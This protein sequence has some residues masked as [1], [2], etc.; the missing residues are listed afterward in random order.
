VSVKFYSPYPKSMTLSRQRA[1]GDWLPWQHYADDCQ[2]AFSLANNGQLS[3]PDDINCLQFDTSV[4]SDIT[5]HI[6]V[7]C[8]TDFIWVLL[9]YLL[10]HILTYDVFDSLRHNL[11]N[12]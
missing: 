8:K 6:F 3:D 7:K 11:I 1:S 5:V 2:Q 12:S 9:V 4:Y 10:F